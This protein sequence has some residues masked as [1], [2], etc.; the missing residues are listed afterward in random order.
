MSTGKIGSSMLHSKG[1][2]AR[3]WRLGFTLV[4]L[5]LVVALFPATQ[6]AADDGTCID[7]VTGRTNICASRGVLAGTFYNQGEPIACEPGETVTLHLRAQLVSTLFH[8][9]DIGLFV[10]TDGGDARTGACFHDYLP[11]PLAGQGE[12]NPGG[13]FPGDPGGPFFNAEMVWDP[14]D[15]CG[16]LE[17]GVYTYHDIAP[18]TGIEV[19]C[20]DKDGDSYLDVDA[21]VSWDILRTVT[22]LGVEDAIPSSCCECRCETLTVG[23]VIVVDPGKIQMTK[24]ASPGSVDEPGGDVTFTFT[25]KNTSEVGIE[26]QALNDTDFGDLTA[27]PDTT[28]ELPQQL[29]SQQSYSC[30]ITAPIGGP[31]GTHENTVTAEGVDENDNEVMDSATA[32]V[33]ITDLLPF[34][35]V[36]KTADPTTVAEPGGTILYTV[37]VTNSSASSDPVTLTTLEDDV[38]GDLT[39][40][41]NSDIANSTCGLVTIAAGDT[42]ECTFEANVT[43]EA[44]DS[45]T[46]T[47]TAVGF[48]DEENEAEASDDATVTI[49]WEPP[50]TGAG[51]APM[52]V[53][54]GLA[55]L[56]SAI[57][58]AGV[59]LRR[60]EL[61]TRNR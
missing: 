42:Y 28:C 11:P 57:L 34:V 50:D 43:G 13:P 58:A 40:P 29:G 27:Y 38:Y 39:D 20:V 32:Q 54:G 2:A 49:V 15:E 10:A 30:A 35:A 5:A 48:D 61:G 24:S 59:W 44:G 8:R 3:K 60:H 36:V 33:L 51:M 6:A 41:N 17:G 45:V 9:A 47:V 12:Y 22:C 46:D 52:A 4:L 16:D 31:P 14:E 55:A 37:Q 7:D 18:T 53:G 56:G 19:P 26:I 1:S 21:C 25:V 23:N